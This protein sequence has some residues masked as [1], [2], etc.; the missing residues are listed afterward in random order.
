MPLLQEVAVGEAVPEAHNVLDPQYEEDTEAEPDKLPDDEPHPLGEGSI[1]P[2][3]A[4]LVEAYKLC[5][6][7]VL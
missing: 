7:A 5:E 4:L 3:G 2:E 1:E 6:G